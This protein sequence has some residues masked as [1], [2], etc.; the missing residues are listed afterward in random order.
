MIYTANDHEQLPVVTLATTF[1]ENNM[2]ES[3]AEYD[4]G[5]RVR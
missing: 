5:L 4:A 1:A 2:L 3:I